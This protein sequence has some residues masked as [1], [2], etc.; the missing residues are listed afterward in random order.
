MFTANKP[1]FEFLYAYINEH[2]CKLSV[3]DPIFFSDDSE[4]PDKND[5]PFE[6]FYRGPRTLSDQVLAKHNYPL[7]WLEFGHIDEVVFDRAPQGYCYGLRYQMPVFVRTSELVGQKGAV[8]ETFRKDLQTLGVGDIISDVLEKA[9]A[10]LHKGFSPGGNFQFVDNAFYRVTGSSGQL[11][12]N[13]V[14]WWVKKWSVDVNGDVVD[15]IS[16]WKDVLDNDPTSRAKTINW[17][18]TVF[19]EESLT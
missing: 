11:P 8:H 10:D 9:W 5:R 17:D 14:N 3:D 4:R 19:E 15:T 16:E 1:I 7:S 18:F 12:L 13:D 2:F 6:N